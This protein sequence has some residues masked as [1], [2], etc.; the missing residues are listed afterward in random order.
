MQKQNSNHI[1]NVRRYPNPEKNT[2]QNKKIAPVGV[3][4]MNDLSDI[5]DSNRL[6]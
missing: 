6:N 4:M 1:L 5:S 3:M 2:E